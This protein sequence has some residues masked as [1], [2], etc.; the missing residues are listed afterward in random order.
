MAG[1]VALPALTTGLLWAGGNWCATYATMF[2]GLTLG[3][4]LVQLN[5]AVAGL[6]GV[7]YYRELQTKKAVALFFMWIFV[8]LWGVMLLSVA[9]S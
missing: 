3:Y 8:L 4:P 2:L 7:F 5:L 6:W 1:E 9:N